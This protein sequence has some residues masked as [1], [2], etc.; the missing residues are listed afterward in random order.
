MT[1]PTIT[2]KTMCGSCI[3]R[4][5]SQGGISLTPERRAEIVAYLM[6][7]QNQLCHSDNNKTICRGG[8]DYQLNLWARLGIISAPTDEALRQAMTLSG[9]SP[10]SHV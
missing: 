10:K 5:E 6:E 4:P 7:G 8:R 1:I 2:R 3:M 9:I